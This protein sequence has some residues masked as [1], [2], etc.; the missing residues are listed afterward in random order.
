MLLDDSSLLKAAASSS[1]LNAIFDKIGEAITIVD[2]TW[3]V[4]YVNDVY[5]RYSGLTRLQVEGRLVSEFA[6]NFKQS[7]FFDSIERA[8]RERKET[9]KVSFSPVLKQWMRCRTVPYDDGAA[10]FMRTASED[11][12]TEHLRSE[13]SVT[14]TLTGLRNKAGLGEDVSA[15]ITKR[16]PFHLLIIGIE[17]L[18]TVNDSHGYDIVDMCL[19]ELTAQLKASLD[20]GD[21]LYRIATDELGAICFGSEDE[22]FEKARQLC[23]EISLP[24]A[25]RSVRIRLMA[26]VGL[27][28]GLDH[29]GSGFEQMLKRCSL[30]LTRA[31]R[32]RLDRPDCL[33][34]IEVFHPALEVAASERV[35]LQDELRSALPN[36]QFMLLIQPK[37]SLATGAVVGGE[38][39]L[40]W[41]HPTRG[42][43]SPGQFLDAAAD[44]GLMPHIDEWVLKN[45]IAI[46][47]ALEDAGAAKTISVNLGADSFDDA[48]L[49]AKIRRFL[50]T[51]QLA[52]ELLEL[53]IPEGALMRDVERAI[54]I[55][56]ELRMMGILLSI[57]DFGTG[58]S[59]FAYLAQF[60]VN[61][62]KI[63]RSFINELDKSKAKRTI[64]RSIIMM[65]HH[66][67]LDVVAEGAEDSGQISV[68]KRLH[69]DKIQGYFYAKPLSF[70]DFLDFQRKLEPT[71]GMQPDAY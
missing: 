44:I 7:I 16:A 55:M 36:H 33:E 26:S 6:P 40:R 2:D 17:G 11:D 61:T 31:R 23:I 43:L 64:V 48:L 45:S 29:S 68:L 14:D 22:A 10:I 50:E 47:K 8:I 35:K 56:T 66:L 1:D 69:C 62:L 21:S 4:K 60:P 24:I 18:K 71:N 9:R 19:L 59:S 5:F 41:V 57:D 51:S 54:S 39:L 28:G 20:P 34:A 53:E 63:D 37:V 65:A 49:P 25:L 3:R 38:T 13:S 32:M 67:S 30:A 12:V 52:P 46:A 42:L 27:V 58:Y 70:D 15:L